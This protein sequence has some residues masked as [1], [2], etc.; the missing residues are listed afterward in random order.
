MRA[1]IVPSAIGI[2]GFNEDLNLIDF[3]LFTKDPIF[4]SKKIKALFEK[5]LIAEAKEIIQRLSEQKF[6]I[7]YESLEP[8]GKEVFPDLGNASPTPAGKAFRAN[9]RKYA[10]ETGFATSEKELVDILHAATLEFVKSQVKV[11]LAEQDK[12]IIQAIG[13]IDELDK[14]ANLLA[15]R[16]REW[17]AIHF[18]ELAQKV[19]SHDTFAKLI[20]DIGHREYFNEQKLSKFFESAFSKDLTQ[21]AKIS[22][23]AEITE[24]DLNTIKQ[25]AQIL[26]SLYETRMALENYTEQVMAS[27]APNVYGLLG[28]TLGARVISLAGGL[29]KLARLPASTIQVLGAEKALFKHLRG[30]AP[31]PKHGIL[32][33]HSVIHSSPKWQRGKIARALA[34]KIAIAARV[35][36]YSKGYSVDSLRADFEKRVEE[37]SEKYATALPKPVIRKPEKRKKR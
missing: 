16:L 12:M 18:P 5:E 21:V 29:E 36:V 17:Y 1:Y 35:D 9:F 23:G 8:I 19:A 14:S 15:S 11:A 6:E 24:L 4:L 34:G 28:A 31:S 10:I 7:I 13:A 37:I 26:L 20:L 33:Q 27:V 3:N 32:F 2:F 22:M 25:F 30:K